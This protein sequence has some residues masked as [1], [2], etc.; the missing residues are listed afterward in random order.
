MKTFGH[1]LQIYPKRI[2]VNNMAELSTVSETLFVPMLGRIYS[3]KEHP[4]VFRD[5]F[6]LS[7]E[8]KLPKDLLTKGHQSEYTLM[9]SAI[10]SKNIDDV[11]RKFLEKNPDSIV[12]ELGCGLETTFLRCDNGKVRWYFLDLPEVLDFRATVLPPSER[13]V[14][15]PESMLERGW[16]EKVKAEADGKP[17]LVLAEGLLYYFTKKDVLEMLRSISSIL[18][19]IIVFDTVNHSGIQMMSRYMKQVGHADAA[20][21]FYVDKAEAL[22]NEIGPRI[23][24]IEEKPFYRG[25]PRKEM[26][27][28]STRVSMTVSDWFSMVKLITL[29][30]A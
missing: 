22:A 29:K 15:L 27:S 5:E 16:M 18:G 30:L 23:S 7:F 21:F 10:R 14:V 28:F 2:M 25:I 12:V 6:A 11:V 20:M 3:S 8:N 26:K 17:I 19:G 1:S 24:V 9:A 13:N 4:S